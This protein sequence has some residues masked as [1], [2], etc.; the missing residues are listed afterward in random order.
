MRPRNA[1]I[2]AVQ[3]GP[4]TL[5]LHEFGRPSVPDDGALLR[6]EACGLCGTDVAQFDGDHARMGLAGLPC[7]PGHEPVGLIEEIGP[8]AAVRWNVA[9]GDRVAIE[10]HL[11]CGVCDACLDGQRNACAVGEHRDVNYGFIGTD[12]GCGLWGGY[13]QYMLLDPRTVMHKV[14]KRLSPATAS[15]FNPIG[16][17]IRWA[18]RAPSTKIGDTVVVLG[19]GQR[20]LACVIALRVAGAG[21]V[22]VTDL[23]RCSSKLDLALEL[24][25][26]HVVVAD[27]EDVVERVT[28]LTG[29]RLAD[30]VIDVTAGATKP[31]TD[32]IEIVKR[33]GTIILAGAK[34][35]KAIPDFV[36]DKVV[37]KSIRMQ[38]VFA[39]DSASFREAIRLI[40]SN[41]GVF[42][43]MHSR[44]YPLADAAQAIQRLSG[45][46]GEPPAIHVAIE[47]WASV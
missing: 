31:V 24:G 35:G 17:G 28:E 46:D 18:C 1:V 45:A 10:P 44:S 34:E 47:P 26:D 7:I 30:V 15:M 32:A 33:G 4:H 29:G 23:A 12:V 39:V 37:L 2:A 20:G 36:S 6:V 22:I 16:A 38:G 42:A 21:M 3:T 11:S 14:S 40:E 8:S 13:S 19:S 41:T 27:E 43:R 25:A 9:A 5:E